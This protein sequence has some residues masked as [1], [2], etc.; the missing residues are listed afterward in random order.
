MPAIVP[1]RLLA[2]LVAAAERRTPPRPLVFHLMLQA[3]LRVG[4]VCK[5]CWCDLLH[6][7][8]P[9]TA[10]R[11]D[12]TIT[13]NHRQRTVP[14]NRTL[15]SFIHS[16]WQ[17]HATPVAMRLCNPVTSRRPTSPI[18]TTRT[19]Q[20]WIAAIGHSAGL[21]HL[22]PHVLRHTFATHLLKVT[23]IRSVQIALGH[24]NLQT[25]QTYTH[26][27]INDLQA[28]VDRLPQTVAPD[29]GT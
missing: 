23:D 6:D 15:T 22:T 25:T 12:A 8:L 1:D 18:T 16:T 2:K 9:K 24:K 29:P 17:H 3:G 26:P 19:V 28:A 11:L 5:L 13:K 7:Y 21:D 20:R 10:I 14:I 4:E 27:D